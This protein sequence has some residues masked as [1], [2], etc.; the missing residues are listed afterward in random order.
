MRRVPVNGLRAAAGEFDT[1]RAITGRLAKVDPT[2][3]EMVAARLT[4]AL[5]QAIDSIGDTTVAAVAA[6]VRGGS[7]GGPYTRTRARAYRG[8]GGAAV[9]AATAASTAASQTPLERGW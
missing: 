4:A 7:V 8:A 2:L 1:C 9:T 5:R 6:E 3:A